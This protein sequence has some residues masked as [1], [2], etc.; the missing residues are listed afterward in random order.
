MAIVSIQG[1]ALLE[2][3]Q[4]SRHESPRVFSLESLPESDN[5]LFQPIDLIVQLPHLSLKFRDVPLHRP[6]SLLGVGRPLLEHIRH[7]LQEFRLPTGIHD[8]V[9]VMAGCNLVDG[10]FFQK[11]LDDDLGLELGTVLRSL[12]NALNYTYDSL[13]CVSPLGALYIPLEHE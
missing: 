1:R 9:D 13:L 3:F 4:T 12:I 5:V 10:P 6:Q 7:S 2:S 8:R 11:D